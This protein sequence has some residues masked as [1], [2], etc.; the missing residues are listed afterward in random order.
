MWPMGPEL[1]IEFVG[2]NPFPILLQGL[3]TFCCGN[4]QD[5]IFMGDGRRGLGEQSTHSHHVF[6]HGYGWLQ[7]TS[8]ARYRTWFVLTDGFMLRPFLESSDLSC[9][10]SRPAKNR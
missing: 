7:T 6:S 1:M 4:R 2:I 8:Q 10:D 3:S 9:T 5:E